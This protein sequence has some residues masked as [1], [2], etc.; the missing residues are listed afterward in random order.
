MSPQSPLECVITFMEMCSPPTQ[1]AP[2][3]PAMRL[4]VM[5]AERCTVAFY[6]FLYN[7]V[8]ERW[9]W[10][11]RRTLP[12]RDL[13][14]IIQDP[15]VEILV[16]HGGGVPA[17]FAE[18]DR[19]SGADIQLAYFG[20]MAEFIGRGLGRF[21]LH[22]TVNAAWQHRPQRL[23][24]HTCNFDHPRAFALYQRAGFVPYR[25][26]TRLLELSVAAPGPTALQ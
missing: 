5:R 13:A 19:R 7:T 25:Q 24:L 10:T 23:W 11:D 21:W 18:I 6:R 3:P 20:L 14:A 22:W 16:L 9:L 2:P 17:G 1:P 12:D 4:A 15:L 8:G 26:E